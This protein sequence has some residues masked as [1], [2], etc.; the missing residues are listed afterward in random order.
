MPK[1]SS[2]A[3][4]WE[5]QQGESSPAYEAFSIY[6]D[7]GADRALRTV[8]AQLSKSY[9]L[10]LRWN[11]RWEWQERVREYDNSLEQKAYKEAVKRVTEMQTR[12]I[13]TAVLMQKKAVEA[14]DKLPLELLSA[15]DI[16]R[17]IKE[18]SKLERDTRTADP[19]ITARQKQE[20]E[21]GGASG[22]ADAILEAWERRKD[23]E[24]D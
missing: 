1:K 3:A 4:A 17:L 19:T 9:P 14:L 16:V 2:G 11:K 6:R 12:H 5:R 21:Q 22:L 23:S 20:E 18:G 24:D 15:N 10:I 13:K 7:M 8:A